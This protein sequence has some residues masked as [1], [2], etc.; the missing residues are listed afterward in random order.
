MVSANHQQYSSDW[1][2]TRP[3]SSFESES[4]RGRSSINFHHHSSTRRPRSGILTISHLSKTS[5]ALLLVVTHTTSTTSSASF[6]TVDTSR[7]SP[8]GRLQPFNPNKASL[9]ASC[10]SSCAT[11]TSHGACAPR[12]E[13][14]GG[15][16]ESN[17][18]KIKH[19]TGMFSSLQSG[20]TVVWLD[21]YHRHLFEARLV[22][23]S[24]GLRMMTVRLENQLLLI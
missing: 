9:G 12:H 7:P 17:G 22:A 23:E 6:S 3:S 5:A 2:V 15:S 24:F 14:V 1:L 11:H 16:R 19:I 8:I 18:R 10:G 13:I 4:H 21:E 20:S